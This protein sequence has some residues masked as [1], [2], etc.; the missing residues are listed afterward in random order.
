MDSWGRSSG[1]YFIPLQRYIHQDPLKAGP[2]TKLEDYPFSS[3]REY[4]FS[5]ELVD[6]GQISLTSLSVDRALAFAL[7][8]YHAFCWLYLRTVMKL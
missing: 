1:R 3:Y 8:C 4:F 7:Y 5:G 2:V 6:T